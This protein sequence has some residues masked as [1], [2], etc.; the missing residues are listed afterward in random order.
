MQTPHR[1]GPRLEEN[2][3]PVPVSQVS[4]A[5]TKNTFLLARESARGLAPRLQAFHSRVVFLHVVVARDCCCVWEAQ[6]AF[7]SLW[8]AFGGQVTRT[9]SLEAAVEAERDVWVWNWISAA[10]AERASECF[11]SQGFAVL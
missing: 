3:Q 11:A 2:P 5:G 8:V 10:R 1:K 9:D 6:D 7:C 4:A